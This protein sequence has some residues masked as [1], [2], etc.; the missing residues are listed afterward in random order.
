MLSV[1][2]GSRYQQK[3]ILF[4]YI[5]MFHLYREK[6]LKGCWRRGTPVISGPQGNTFCF[7]QP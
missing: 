6:K 3:T 5:N 1:S 2:V 7:H 4:K